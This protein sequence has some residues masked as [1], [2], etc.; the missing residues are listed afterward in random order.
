V[1]CNRLAL[2]LTGDYT[3]TLLSAESALDLRQD[4]QRTVLRVQRDTS[5]QP[6]ER[7]VRTSTCTPGA[8]APGHPQRAWSHLPSYR[9]G[10]DEWLQSRFLQWE[11]TQVAGLPDAY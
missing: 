11:A 6:S 9:F 2:S 5:G 1:V 4:L 3:A 10:L 7:G 8:G